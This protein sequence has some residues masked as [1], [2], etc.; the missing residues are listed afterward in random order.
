MDPSHLRILVS[1]KKC[2]LRS[3]ALYN[4][5]KTNGK[6]YFGSVFELA[7]DKHPDSISFIIKLVNPFIINDV[8]V[9]T[10]ISIACSPDCEYTRFDVALLNNDADI[11]YVDSIGYADCR[12]FNT[13]E[14][15]L[16]ERMRLSRI[17]NIE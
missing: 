14:D 17:F 1:I 7:S 10:Y 12:E 4:M 15:L 3:D 16:A 13:V 2:E 5:L 9:I 6:S 8:C 11:I